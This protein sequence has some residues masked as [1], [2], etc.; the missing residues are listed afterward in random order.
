M[1]NATFFYSSVESI[2]KHPIYKYIS[3][4]ITSY[5]LPRE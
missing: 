2:Y 1:G 5:Y 4:K 3:L